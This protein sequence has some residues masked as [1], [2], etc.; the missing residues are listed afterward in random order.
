MTKKRLMIIGEEEHANTI[1]KAI[2]EYKLSIKEVNYWKYT[3]RDNNDKDKQAE[4]FY[5]LPEEIKDKKVDI[6]IFAV[7]DMIASNFSNEII[8]ETI[9]KYDLWEMNFVISKY[10]HRKNVMVIGFK[11]KANQIK[12]LIN[13]NPQLNMNVVDF[14]EYNPK[15]RSPHTIEEISYDLPNELKYMQVE[16]AIFATEE[17]IADHF[18]DDI[19]P[20]WI[21]KYDMADF[22]K[23]IEKK[24]NSLLSKIK[25][26]ITI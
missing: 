7:N 12:E 21:K 13:N 9:E 23:Y 3:P 11:D 5:V 26:L 10:D 1:R 18:G 8:P 16:V 6:I 17:R 22:A 19:V 14:W 25:Q 20:I 2:K 24:N 4:L 15:D